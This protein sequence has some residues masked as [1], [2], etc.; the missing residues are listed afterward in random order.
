[1]ARRRH[2]IAKADSALKEFLNEH[3]IFE[4]KQQASAAIRIAAGLAAQRNLVRMEREM[5]A[6]TLK[7]GSPE[8]VRAERMLEMLERQI[9]EVREGDGSEFFP[10]W[11]DVPGLASEYMRLYEELKMQEFALAYVRLKLEDEAILANRDVNV[12]RV[13]D[14][15]FVPQKRVWP[16]RKQIVLVSTFAVFFWVCFGLIVRER[17]GRD[18]V[19]F[20]SPAAGGETR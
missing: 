1:V 18:L 6:M 16:K 14:P 15:P 19:T 4:I 9:V 7:P 12:I 17:W 11:Q 2:R 13:I 20:E 3:G 10:S 8:L 5:L